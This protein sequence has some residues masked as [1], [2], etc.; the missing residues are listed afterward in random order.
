MA[1]TTSTAA[2]RRRGGGTAVAVLVGLVVLAAS[3]AGTFYLKGGF[4]KT[5]GESVACGGFC[6]PSLQRSDV[7]SALEEQGY[8]CTRDSSSSLC[9][10]QVGAHSFEIMISSPLDD[11]RI[12]SVIS[13]VS[14]PP[15]RLPGSKALPFFTWV[16]SLPFADDQ[17]TVTDI[18]GWV[19]Q[20]LDGGADAHA[21]I[22]G[23]GYE[24][25]FGQ[26]SISL[27]FQG[28]NDA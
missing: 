1:A 16:A 5:I 25:R 2:P 8:R 15:E 14:G 20:Q 13:T 12:T 28:A 24:M 21:Q 22:G 3:A 17:A 23:Y 7:V 27:N 26:A 18:T 6:I 10:L 9:N 19:E 11:D 4:T